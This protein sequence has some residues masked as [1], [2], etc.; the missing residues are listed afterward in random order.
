MAETASPGTIRRQLDFLLNG[1][2]F[3]A[4]A[5][6][7]R[8]DDLLVR[9]CAADALAQAA[10]GVRGGI[11]SYRQRFI[12]D[13]TRQQ[14]LPPAE[15]MAVLRALEALQADLA[16]LQT[17]VRSQ[18]LGASDRTW[19]RLRSAHTALELALAFDHRLIQQADAARDACAALDPEGLGPTPATA[20]PALEAIRAQ[21]SA[22][23]TTLRD[24]ADHLA[25]PSA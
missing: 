18:P 3:Y 5:E 12:P 25:A 8:A 20:G 7:C 6:R 4:H 10:A 23:T 11:A 13:P 2:S 16:D 15:A 1:F 24:R 14:P 22:V 17:Q 9:Q 19:A 21:L